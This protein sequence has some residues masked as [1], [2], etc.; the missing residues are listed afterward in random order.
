[1]GQ[2]T[3]QFLCPI[4]ETLSFRLNLNWSCHPKRRIK[5]DELPY[6]IRKSFPISIYIPNIE[7]LVWSV[8]VNPKWCL[9]TFTIISCSSNLVLYLFPVFFYR[10]NNS[11][12]VFYTTQKIIGLDFWGKLNLMKCSKLDYIGRLDYIRIG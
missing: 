7:I 4:V 12:V 10:V 5:N 1:M 3:E 6:Y 2:L 9:I 8:N 11:Y